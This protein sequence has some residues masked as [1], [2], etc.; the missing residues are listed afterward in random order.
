MP[1]DIKMYSS[2]SPVFVFY[3]MGSVDHKVLL[4]LYNNLD[5][6]S[7]IPFNKLMRALHIFLAF[8]LKSFNIVSPPSFS[9]KVWRDQ[10]TFRSSTQG[11]GEVAEQPAAL[12][13]V[14]VRI[15]NGNNFVCKTETFSPLMH[16]VFT[17]RF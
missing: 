1:L 8:C 6:P 5:L 10:S 17:V 14:R 7:S 13:T 11:P 2:C 9:L 16:H 15:N 4:A 12:Q 3:K